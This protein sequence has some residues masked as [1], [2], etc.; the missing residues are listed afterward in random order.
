[1]SGKNICIDDNFIPEYDE[2]HVISDLHIGGKEGFQIFNSGVELGAFIN[3]LSE[4]KNEKDPILLIINGDFIDFLA[5]D[6]AKYFDPVGAVGKLKRI[7][8]DTE[9]KPVWDALKNFVKA[10]KRRLIINLGN[11]DLELA[12]PWVQECF[13][14][15]VAGDD[16]AARGRIAFVTGG[17]GVLCRV[18]KVR[19]L[20]VHGNESDDWNLVGQT[21]LQRMVG[22]CLKNRNVEEWTPN[23][24]TK[25][26]IDAMNDVK[27]NYPF[28]DLL[29]PENGGA[30]RTLYEVAPEHR[31]KIIDFLKVIPKLT[32]DKLFRTF[33]LLSGAENRQGESHQWEGVDEDDLRREI[34]DC[35]ER[36]ISACE[37]GTAEGEARRLG[38]INATWGAIT[39]GSKAD[40]LREALEGLVK[41]QSFHI[42]NED[43]TFKYY[44][45]NAGDSVNIVIAGHTHLER[46][47]K[48]K[49]SAGWYYNT[50]SWARLIQFTPS[51]LQST[52]LFQPIY[53]ALVA[54][55]MKALDECEGLVI[56]RRTVA[57]VWRDDTVIKSRLRH[58]SDRGAGGPL[59]VDVEGSNAEFSL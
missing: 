59:W 1:M 55:S 19:V 39:G 28:V 16:A 54:G 23:A 12:L 30:I 18:G 48:R 21:D 40:N 29:K 6:N 46:A 10:D 47:V 57:S 8:S 15:E 11:H 36:D 45:K 42:D 7:F 34:E 35:L 26:V 32:K 38:L 9:F 5:E 27:K 56:R 51:V 24:G 4:K 14:R 53:N 31:G 41:D 3:Y 33:G 58:V 13:F 2:V 43:K 52:T 50:G 22:D 37:L 44:D 49:I 25:L 20:C 17:Q